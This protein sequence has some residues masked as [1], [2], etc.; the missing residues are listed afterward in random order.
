M[1][2]VNALDLYSINI[3]YVHSIIK[4]GFG[5]DEA[6]AAMMRITDLI[7]MYDEVKAEFLRGAEI[8]FACSEPAHAPAGL[9]PPELIELIAYEVRPAAITELAVRRINLKFG[10]DA[11]FAVGDLSGRVLAAASGDWPDTIFYNAY[12]DR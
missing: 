6:E 3:N 11:S 2:A 8:V 4:A 5:V 12:K 10:G 7:R 1:D 9:P